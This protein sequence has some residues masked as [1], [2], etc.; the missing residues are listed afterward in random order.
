[1]GGEAAVGAAWKRIQANV[2]ARARPEDFEG[3][4]VQPMIRQSDGYELILGSS[5]DPQFGA[6]L[7][8]GLGGQLVEVFRDRA[9]ALPPLTSTL[10]RR[11]ME[12]TRIYKALAGVRGR[13]P[14]DRGVLEQILVRFSQLVAETHRIREIDINPL[15]ASPTGILAL[16]A[17][18]VL[19]DWSI[20]DRRLPRTSIRP[21]PSA[22]IE[23]WTARDGSPI[24]IRP[25]RPEDEPK[26][27][28]FHERL[29]D[30]SVYLRYFHHVA[31]SARVT[32]DRLTRICFIDYDREMV[33]VA[34]SASG[35]IVAVGRLTR[36]RD[37]AKAE[38]ALLVSDAWQAR[39]LGTALLRRL[40]SL[41]RNEGIAQVFG[42]ILPENRLMQE[43]CRQLGFHLQYS[44]EEG[45]VIGSLAINQ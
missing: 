21:Y 39:G 1:L 15:L 2:S 16:D 7:L 25:I 38:F 45:F 24:V 33:L 10:A 40:V 31:L 4:T 28:R 29:S 12:R 37:P 3:V 9:L 26:M 22:W 8:F 19:H 44:P 30:R 27:V 35:D 5:V 43:V 34:E 32:H 6:V 20:P 14:I 36:E 23:K 13:A 11:M 42:N 18:V 17:R 41:A